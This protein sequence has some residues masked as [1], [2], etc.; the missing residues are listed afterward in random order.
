MCG[1]AGIVAFNEPG[2]VFLD[3]I[4]ASVKTLAQRGPDASGVYRGHN[5][6][7]GH[8]RLKIIDTSEAASQPFTD[9]SGRYTIIY[10]GEFYN[11]KEHRAALEKDGLKF[12]SSSDTEV[13][14]CLFIREKEKCL[15]KIN[16]FFA[17][18]IYDRVEQSLFLARDRM[19]IK[20]LLVYQDEDKFIF[21]SEMKA[22][23]A[24]EIPKQIDNTSLFTYLQL[25]YVPA[26]DTIFQRVKKL[27]TG[28]FLKLNIPGSQFRV[29]KYYGIPYNPN[30]HLHAPGYHEAQK[31]LIELLEESV[32]KRLV[33]DVPL[34]SFLSGGID[35]SIITA[36]AAKQV[37]HLNTFS[38]GYRD[39][40]FFDET[41][42]ADLVAKKYQTNHTVF[43]LTNKDLYENLYHVL[44]YID[45]PFA[46]SSAIAVN[47]LSRCTKKH[48]TVAL[49]GDG[50]DEIFSGY[51]KHAAEF[52][53]RNA[54]IKE[55][56][57]KWL[58][59]VWK[60]L[61]KSRNSK[62]GNIIR[63]L[64]RF[65]EGMSLPDKERYW[66]WAASLSEINSKKLFPLSKDI[67]S[68]Y[69]KRKKEILKFIDHD[70]NSV[71]YTD[72]LLVLQND[73]LA[74]VDMMS[75]ANGLEVRVPFLDYNV[76]NFVFSLPSGYKIDRTMRK[77]ILQ[78][79]F[80]DYLPAELYNRPKHGFEVPLLKWFRTEMKSVITDDLLGEKFIKDQNIFDMNEVRNLKLKLFSNNPGDVPAV[81]WNLLVF[82]Y[83]WKKNV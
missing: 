35:S 24:F 52:R 58:N 16:G 80:R 79:A 17:L 65:S 51:N 1:I 37:K 5:V 60:A 44:N 72:A 20:P 77:K 69:A 25:N 55:N 29:S 75:M 22:L 33:S 83:W 32:K 26:P 76:V 78:D 46:D 57:V 19:G 62:T 23:L 67:Y 6:A 3:K 43:S 9:S 54:G 34:G 64:H 30:S 7:L 49:S 38:I 47:I 74:K 42:Y 50:A 63:Q 13:L 66:Q 28:S 8:T 11:Y 61:P 21:A 68:E 15:E 12:R 82:Q 73:M 71:L 36:L 40:P 48:V 53:A 18:A 4:D 10:N 41:N 14:L 2:K 59:P 70:Y 45:E 39:E 56:L 27:E 81:I 31:K